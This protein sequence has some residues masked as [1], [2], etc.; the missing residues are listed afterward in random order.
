MLK[1]TPKTNTPEADIA[2]CKAYFTV[3]FTWNHLFRISCVA[4]TEWGCPWMAALGHGLVLTGC[5]P[6]QSHP[7][8]YQPRGCGVT[9]Y[10][11]VQDLW[12]GY[13]LRINLLILSVWNNFICICNFSKEIVNIIRCEDLILMSIFLCLFFLFC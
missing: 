5:V 8:L 12:Q 9:V 10:F 4:V 7:N 1:Q 3:H 13:D 11:L 6:I 2:F